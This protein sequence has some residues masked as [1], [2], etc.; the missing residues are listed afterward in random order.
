MICS[1]KELVSSEV[2]FAI[3]LMELFCSLEAMSQIKNRLE[4]TSSFYKKWQCLV[5]KI[6]GALIVPAT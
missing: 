6:Y 2:G 3:V 1:D 4:L 5:T